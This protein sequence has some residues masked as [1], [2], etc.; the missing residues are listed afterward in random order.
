MLVYDQRAAYRGRRLNAMFL[1]LRGPAERAAFKVDPLATYDRFGLTTE[2]R[3][4]VEACD[5]DGLMQAGLSIYALGK[6][7]PALG[8]DLLEVGADLHGVDRESFMAAQRH[9]RAGG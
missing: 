1:A 3:A 7:L 2:E 8:S 5:W 9:A 6:G 4:L